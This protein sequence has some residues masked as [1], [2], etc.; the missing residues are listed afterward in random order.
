MTL[1][2]PTDTSAFSN[3][4]TVSSDLFSSILPY[5]YVVVG[6]IVAFYIIEKIIDMLRPKGLKEHNDYGGKVSYDDHANVKFIE[7]D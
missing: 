5:L 4:S 1:I 3:L 7:F 2:I 6:I